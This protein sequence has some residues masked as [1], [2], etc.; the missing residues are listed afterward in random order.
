MI[1]DLCP[2]SLTLPYLT[3]RFCIL[4]LL[5]IIALKSIGGLTLLIPKMYK[6]ARTSFMVTKPIEEKYKTTV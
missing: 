1:A 3:Y 5:Y 6:E 2:I 4:H